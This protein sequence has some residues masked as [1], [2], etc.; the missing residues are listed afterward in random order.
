MIASFTVRHGGT[1]ADNIWTFGKWYR[2]YGLFLALIPIAWT[3]SLIYFVNRD[4]DT[5]LVKL[6]VPL[7][8]LLILGFILISVFATMSGIGT[9]LIVGPLK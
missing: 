9:G 7:C 4:W 2:A 6:Y 1:W 5:Q 3:T 8:F